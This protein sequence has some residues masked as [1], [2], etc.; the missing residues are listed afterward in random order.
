MRVRRPERSD[1]PSL[2]RRPADRE[3]DDRSDEPR[4]QDHQH[5]DELGPRSVHRVVRHLDGIDEPPDHEDDVRDE[6]QPEEQPDDDEELENEDSELEELGS[7]GD[8]DLLA[9]DLAR[10]EADL[11]DR[12]LRDPLEQ[13]GER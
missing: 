5:P 13:E 3:V 12:V 10:L 7:P 6:E 9:D 1:G 2:R 4:Q 11:V 8:L